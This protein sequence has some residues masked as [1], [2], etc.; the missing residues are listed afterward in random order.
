MYTMPYYF[1]SFSIFLPHSIQTD[2]SC[3]STNEAV[4]TSLVKAIYIEANYFFFFCKILSE[5]YKL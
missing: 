2:G 5:I 3:L 4:C 1:N